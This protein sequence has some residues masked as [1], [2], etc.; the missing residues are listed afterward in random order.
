M[1]I[2]LELIYLGVLLLIAYAVGRLA[3]RIGLPAIPVYIGVG[4]LA[5]PYV[6]FFPI[7]VKSGDI[8][9]IAVFGL[10]LLL[11]SLGLEFDQDDFY[12]N[13]GKLLLS[14]GTYIL[15]NMVVGI[16][17]GYLLGWGSKEALIVAGITATSSS[18]I[19]TKLL[20]SLQRLA[21]EETP[22][23]LGVTV[24]EDIFIAI[25]LA[26]VS[27]VLDSGVSIVASL[28]KL[29]VAFVFIIAMFAVARYAGK[30]LTRVLRTKDAELFAVGFFGL[31]IAFGGIGEE[32]GV[33]DAIG[34]FLIGLILG[35]TGHRERF[36]H[37][38]LPLRDV[39]GAFF[40]LN[41]G[42]TLNPS[43]FGP[44]LWPVI[45]AVV[46]TFIFNIVAGQI[47]ARINGFGTFEG[48]NTAAILVNRGEFALIL[49]TL[50]AHAHLDSRIVAFAG[51]YVLIMA[52][53]GPILAG[54]SENIARK[55]IR[56]RPEASATS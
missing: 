21:N 10:I 33:T 39:F 29:V 46:M 36:E 35:A 54:Q 7:T 16:G 25:Y 17:Y 2:G 52:V 11:F 40:F 45:G 50:A 41:F 3:T 13:K 15:V 19:V 53:V 8:E 27:V 30:L 49:A 1:H 48:V 34:A 56:R 32:L 31:A 37:I 12:Q 42:L 23:I 38:A 51:L 20:I 24:V 22:M 5:S 55:L 26:I 18:A 9:L 4:L 6:K 14:G 43:T 28:I 44:V 47:V